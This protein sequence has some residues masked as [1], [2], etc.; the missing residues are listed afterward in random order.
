[1]VDF[2]PGMMIMWAVASSW[3]LVTILMRQPARRKGSRS[4]WFETRGRA[5]T[6]MF[7]GV[8]GWWEVFRF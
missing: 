3:G 2:E 8:E 6:A 7:M 4:S 5:M 1:M